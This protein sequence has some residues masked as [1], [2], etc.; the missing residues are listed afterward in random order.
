MTERGKVSERTERRVY[1]VERGKEKKDNKKRRWM[2]R[3][4]M[5][6]K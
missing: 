3:E 2:G 1:T 5:N 6:E 4:N